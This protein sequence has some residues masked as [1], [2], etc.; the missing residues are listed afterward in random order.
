VLAD[1]LGLPVARWE[2]NKNGRDERSA[3]SRAQVELSLDRI[4]LPPNMHIRHRGT[5]QV[6][7]GLLRVRLLATIGK[8]FVGGMELG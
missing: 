7:T 8:R 6:R 3:R 1:H 2:G 5:N 4:Q